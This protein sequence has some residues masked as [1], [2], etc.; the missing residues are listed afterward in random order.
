MSRIFSSWRRPIAPPDADM[1]IARSSNPEAVEKPRDVLDLKLFLR[2]FSYTKPHARQRNWLF[3]LVV[4]RGIQIPLIGWAISATING[5]IARGDWPATM[6]ASFGFLAFCAFTQIT[7]HYRQRIALELGENA[8]FDLREQLVGH[9]FR[10]PMSF[11]HRYKLGRLLSRVTSDI[12][13]IR[14]GIQNV[15]FVSMVQGCQM[16]GA[17]ALMAWYNWRLFLAILCMTPLMYG[18]HH[19]FRHRISEASRAVQASFSRVTS[20]LA[21][22]VKGIRVTQGFVREEVNAGLFSRLVR[23]HSRYNLNVTRNTSIYLPLLELN[24]QIFLGLVMALAAWGSLRGGWDTNPGDLVTFFFLSG[25]F[26]SPIQ[27][28]GN[29]FQQALA[30]MAGAERVFRL[31]DTPP[32]W[33]DDAEAK[34]IEQLA[35]RV[36][37]DNVAFYYNP[38]ER[39]LHGISFDAQPGQSVAL[40]GHTGSGKSTIIQ[41]LTKFYLAEEGRI[42]MDGIDVTRIQSQSLHRH[43]AIVLQQNFLFAGTVADNIRLGKPSATDAEVRKALADLDCL[44]LVEAMPDGLQTWISENGQGLSLGQRQIVCFARALIANPSILLLDEAT[45]SVDTLT[46]SRLQIALEKLLKGRTS[47]IVAHRLSTIRS[48]DQILVLD[49]G[50]IVER[51]NHAS[52]VASDGIYANLYRQFTKMKDSA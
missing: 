23:D 32:E 51:G 26:F 18:V 38:G 27:A 10:Q 41:L 21:E 44:D 13:V 5:P 52:L 31:L 7:M 36:E 19:I 35:G 43:M 45:S 25:V 34:P 29:Q 40:V 24:G 39:V 48:A 9:L 20:S 28:L 22:S 11:F 33:S 6:A 14:A 2:M 4:I 16:I 47:F 17:A 42:L 37:F 3:A 1:G 30:S 12:E 15:L 8:I 49:H 50:R 46:E